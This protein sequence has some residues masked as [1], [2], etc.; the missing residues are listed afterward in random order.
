MIIK[1]IFKKFFKIVMKLC[2]KCKIP[3]Y[4]SKYCNKIYTNVQHLYLLVAQNYSN[5]GY[6]KFV[7]SLYDSKIPF[8]ISLRKIPHF[9]TLQKF[10]KRLKAS[11]LDKLIFQTKSLFEKQGTIFG[12]DSTGMELDH[13]SHHYC[14]RINRTKPVKG[15]VKFNMISDLYNKIILVTKIRKKKRH[16]SYDFIPMYNKIKKLDFDY[17]VAD[18]GYDGE[19]NHEVIF[20]SGKTSLISLKCQENKLHRTKGRFRKK[21]KRHF[22]HGIYTQRNLT[23]SIFSAIKRKFGAKLKARKYKTQK[24][25]LLFKVLVY[26]IE[27]KIRILIFIIY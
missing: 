17:F 26:N 24:I 18:K 14:L 5:F 21:V 6:R 3:L 19:K 4:F 25:E 2:S 13:A 20:R 12:T 10:A 27:R 11:F 15:F 7:E 9:T 16:D 22:E 23:E 8:Y 1:R